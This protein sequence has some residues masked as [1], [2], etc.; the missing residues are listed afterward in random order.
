MA[1]VLQAAVRSTTRVIHPRVARVG[2]EPT[3][4]PGLSRVALPVCV[5]CRPFHFSAPGGIR[6]R[7]LLADNEASTPGCSTKALLMAQ[8]GLEPSASLVLSE[9]GLPI[10]YR[11][12][13]V[14]PIDPVPGVG[15][16]PTGTR[17]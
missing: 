14:A 6:T 7:D 5:P 2:V 17:V 1:T 12:G 4:S 3:E 16:E 8:E 11:A 10:A 9:S 15:V 13:N